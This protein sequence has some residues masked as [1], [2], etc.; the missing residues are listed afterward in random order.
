[1][2]HSVPNFPHQAIN[3]AETP[4]ANVNIKDAYNVK[5]AKVLGVLHIICGT[6][7]LCAEIGYLDIVGAGFK[8]HGPIIP[9]SLGTGI[10]TS[11]FFS[12]QS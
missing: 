2:Q 8:L 4:E 1:M 5:A 11:A 12:I 10:W 7:A 9:P 3:V 6:V